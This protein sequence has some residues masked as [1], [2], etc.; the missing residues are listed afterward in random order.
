M[1]LFLSAI[2]LGV[3]LEGA[4]REKPK[5][6]VLETAF[7]FI[8]SFIHPFIHSFADSLITIPSDDS[9]PGPVLKD[10]SL[11]GLMGTHLCH[12]WHCHWLPMSPWA[13]Y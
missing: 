12:C 1:G 4:T 13:S 2:N 11:S 6:R 3:S 9:A 7:L 5:G 8:H 10:L